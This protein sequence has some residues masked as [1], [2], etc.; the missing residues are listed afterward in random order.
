M[1]LSWYM[2]VLFQMAG[3]QGPQRGKN[4]ILFPIIPCKAMLHPLKNSHVLF[5]VSSIQ[6]SFGSQMF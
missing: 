4:D 5:L 6:L 3:Q 2:S 1:P